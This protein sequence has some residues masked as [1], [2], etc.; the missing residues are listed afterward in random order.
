METTYRSGSLIIAGLLIVLI[1]ASTVSAE[2][3]T[4]QMSANP[5]TIYVYN[6]E[7]PCTPQSTLVT[8]VVTGYGIVTSL[9]ETF[10]PSNVNVSEVTMPYIVNE[11]SFSIA[12]D[13]IVEE[14]G[15][16]TITWLNVGQ[17]VGNYDTWL[18]A[19]ETFMV[20]FDAGS[21]DYGPALAV[22]DPTAAVN[23]IDPDGVAQSQA[24][25]Q[26]YLDVQFCNEPPD[27]TQAYSS[28]D[29]IWPPNHKFVT[30]EILG[31]T[32]PDGDPFTI[33]IT[34]ITSDQATATELGAGGATHAPDA[35]GVGTSAFEVRAERSG[36]DKEGRVYTVT[37]T[38]DDSL[39]NGESSGTVYVTVPHDQRKQKEPSDAVNNGKKYDA[40]AIN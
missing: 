31:V 35:N 24:I 8:L 38:A 27:V 17:Y 4:V 21:S 34:G 20:T 22:N 33:T 2:D 32:D 18:E 37:F 5:E 13:S 25:P 28:V 1:L 39:P 6:P 26:V 15:Q 36:R 7:R 40:T 9:F 10:A 30:G 23:Y 14:G 16:T 11:G 19:T 29:R 3:L 12:P